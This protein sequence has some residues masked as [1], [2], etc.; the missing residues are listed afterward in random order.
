MKALKLS[1]FV[2][3]M[4]C[5]ACEKEKGTAVKTLPEKF[6]PVSQTIKDYAYF[7]A[8]SYWIMR[9]S[10]SGALDS[11]YV[12]SVTTG[13]V[14][15]VA[16]DTT[17]KVEQITLRFKS[18]YIPNGFYR[19]ERDKVYSTYTYDREYNYAKLVLDSS[20]VKQHVTSDGYIWEWTRF[21][22]R[23]LNGVPYNHVIRVGNSVAFKVGGSS[24]LNY[25]AKHIGIIGVNAYGLHPQ[26]QL[27]RYKVFQ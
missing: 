24:E 19:L 5:V 8:G 13:T 9:D 22:S 11:T 4:S 27:L 14:K 16:N 25:W 15:S 20:L 6:V 23:N 26:G 18:T 3:L 21:L 10:T 1:F 7:K 17:Y 12:E 2:I